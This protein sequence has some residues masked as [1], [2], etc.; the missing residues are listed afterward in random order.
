MGCMVG[1]GGGVEKN[2]P[3]DILISSCV[4]KLVCCRVLPCFVVFCRV[5]GEFQ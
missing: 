1:R 5:E 3:S 2:S 4:F